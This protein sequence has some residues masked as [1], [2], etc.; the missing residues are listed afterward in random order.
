MRSNKA[1]LWMCLLVFL[2]S[3]SL[4]AFA[5][6]Q[7]Q[8]QQQTQS[9]RARISGGGGSGKCTFEVNV[10][11]SAEVQIRGDE[12]RLRWISGGP[13]S[14]KRLDCNQPLPRNPNNF[15]FQ[16]IDGRGSQ[17]LV[18]EPA[19]NRGVAVIRIDDPRPGSEGYTGDILWDG[20]SNDLPSGNYSGGGYRGDW[21]DLQITRAEYGY[22]NRSQDVTSRLNSQI[23]DNQLNL[24]VSNDTMGGDPAKGRDKTLRVQYTYNGQPGQ[25]TVNEGGY[26]TLPGSEM[27]GGFQSDR[28][29]RG[30]YGNNL[31]I[32]RADYGGGNSYMDVTSRL[33]SMIQGGQLSLQI[34]NNTMGGDPAVGQDKTLQIQYKY[35][36]RVAQ[37]AVSEG[38]YLR[39]P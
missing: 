9:I 23:R 15:H 24:Q 4:T 20:G 26:L 1:L 11:G 39:L 29:S 10:D 8:S 13:V 18:R 32:L 22:G 36:G 16:G 30:G 3:A 17:T 27:G 19:S 25:V 31:Q 21:N 28:P 33:S 6:W 12:G 34:N 37:I 5:Q 35:N 38:N 7:S 14:W 2:G